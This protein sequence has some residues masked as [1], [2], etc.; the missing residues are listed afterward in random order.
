MSD[1]KCVSTCSKRA[2]LLTLTTW[3]KFHIVPRLGNESF[4][5]GHTWS[6]S[7]VADTYT[8]SDSSILRNGANCQDEVTM[9]AQG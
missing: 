7:D 1:A 3:Q 6:E 4:T 2:V 8:F 9:E 5:C